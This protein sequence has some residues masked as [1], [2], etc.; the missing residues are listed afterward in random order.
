RAGAALADDER[1]CAR[2]A[3]RAARGAERELTEEAFESERPQR[4]MAAQARTS[5]R[6]SIGSPA[7]ARTPSYESTCTSVARP[8][9]L[10]K[11]PPGHS[12]QTLGE[13]VLQFGRVLMTR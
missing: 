3:R 8:R 2:R 4:R 7:R 1:S 9:N 6:R 5:L 13:V 10:G 11:Q 12:G